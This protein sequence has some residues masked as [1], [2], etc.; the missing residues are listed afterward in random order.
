MR[1]LL[2]PLLPLLLLASL[3]ACTPGKPFA[4][5]QPRTDLVRLADGAAGRLSAQLQEE[6]RAAATI[7]LGRLEPVSGASETPLSEMLMEQVA[8]ALVRR[9]HAI[10]RNPAPSLPELLFQ[11]PQRPRELTLRGVAPT[12]DLGGS[13]AV[14]SERV[15]VSLRV[16]DSGE[17]R[18]LAADDFDLRQD[19]DVRALLVTPDPGLYRRDLAGNYYLAR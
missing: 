3:A 13:Y 16:A 8:A 5:F 11:G 12:L 14:G 9:G 17:Q 4:A 19:D 10:D 15:F 1:R 2:A 7:R 18:L 6:G